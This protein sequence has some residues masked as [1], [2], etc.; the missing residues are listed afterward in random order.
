V[1]QLIKADFFKIEQDG[2]MNFIKLLFDIPSLNLR[3]GLCALISI[4]ACTASGI[5]Y[6]N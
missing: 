3:H 1:A 5:E 4:M 6:L 2:S